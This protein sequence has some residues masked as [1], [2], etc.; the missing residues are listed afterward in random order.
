MNQ[1]SFSQ[2]HRTL[3][4]TPPA[5][6]FPTRNST[7]QPSPRQGRPL[8][9]PLKN[10]THNVI[11]ITQTYYCITV[12]TLETQMQNKYLWYQMLIKRYKRYSWSCP[13]KILQ[14]WFYGLL[15]L[16][17]PF[18]FLIEAFCLRHITKSNFLI[19]IIILGFMRQILILNTGGIKG[20]L[21]MGIAYTEGN[22]MRKTAL[23]SR[24]RKVCLLTYTPPHL[25]SLCCLNV[26]HPPFHTIYN[27]WHWG[28]V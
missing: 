18:C 11:V 3:L 7:L 9:T 13:I 25:I 12:I 5:P 23:K 10:R 21:G 28:F 4:R 27:M 20:C 15:S 6:R 8:L 1:P 19:L 22:I 17:D 2:I 24:R 26:S 16:Y 14:K